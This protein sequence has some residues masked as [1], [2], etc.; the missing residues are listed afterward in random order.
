VDARRPVLTPGMRL[1]AYEVVA[2]VG[3]GGMGEV[4]R[5]RDTRLGRDAAL[6]LLPEGF[7]QD[8]ERHARFEREAK[9]LASLNHP[10]IATLYGLEHLEGQHA[11][12]MELVEGEGLN[13]RIARG[14]LP[15]DE[16]VRIAVQIAEALEAAHEKGIVHRD[17]KP[18]NVKVRPDGVVKVLDFGL[19][20]AWEEPAE[21]SDPGHS[22]T[23]TGV[24]TRVGVILGTAAY[25]SP[26]QA[27][28]RPVDKRAD[29]WAFGCVLYEMLAGVAAFRGET[30]PDVM[31]AIVARDPDWRALPA[32]LPEGVRRVLGRCLDRDPTRRL[33][34]I[35][36]ARVALGDAAAAERVPTASSLGPAAPEV[37]TSPQGTHPHRQPR[38]RLVGVVVVSGVIVLAAAV[39]GLRAAGWLPAVFGHAGAG[40]IRSL[41][42]LPLENLSGDPGQAYF[43]DGMTEALINTL[44]QIGALSVISRTTVMQFKGTHLSLPEIAKRLNDV[45]AVIE[46][47]VQRAG[48]HVRV[49]VQLVRAATDTP[50][51]AKDYDSELTDVLSLQGEVARAIA[52]QVRVE[53]TPGE[54]RRLTSAPS[55]NAEAY[56]LYLRGKTHS[57]HENRDDND[58]AIALLERAV[59]VD[60]TFAAA[61][62][63]LARAYGIRHFFFAPND[64]DLKRRMELE[65]ETALRLDPESSD[66]HLARG[67]LL[68]DASNHFPHAEAIRELRRAIELNPSSDEAHHQL[69][70]VYLHVGL[71]DKALKEVQEAIRLNPDNTLAPYRLGCVKLY[72]GDYQQAWDLFS[73]IPLN[74]NPVLLNYVSAWTLFDLGRKGEAK[75]RTDEYARAYPRDKGGLNASLQAMFA[76]DAGDAATAE[77]KIYA[78]LEH[79]KGYRH[80]HHTEYNVAVAYALLG[81]PKDA[82]RWLQAAADDG[83]PCYPLFETDPNL[84]KIRHD[85]GFM[86]FLVKQKQQWEAFR[87]L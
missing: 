40:P 70:L 53:L 42:V 67:V 19:A 15:V 28:G 17:L 2:L 34:D 38:R 85:P 51:W 1:G 83:L 62:A 11:L 54:R 4:W 22:P 77:A 8:P 64:A 39:L 44:A 16:A 20:K 69:A 61:H 74:Y 36:E 12:V 79:G 72:K 58:E 76:A 49:S 56:D 25:M 41:A 45:D 66:A 6:K 24:Y 55:V 52:E 57:R 14:P 50:L 63:E 31:A 47:S 9:V 21:G 82:L 68:W 81:K 26:E 65:V 7:A 75:A 23:V 84:D 37:P 73:K 43:A 32:A 78:A 86:A 3:A 48:R 71:L 5:A 35:G 27:R 13:E 10:H 87:R 30:V 60:P 80:V 46:G 29:I 33:R 18:A 59:A